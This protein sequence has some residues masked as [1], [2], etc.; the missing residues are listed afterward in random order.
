M[1]NRKTAVKA[2]R[3]ALLMVDFGL[4]DKFCDA[5]ELKHPW[6]T[7]R[8]TDELIFFFSVFFNIK[9]TTLLKLYYKG[10]DSEDILTEKQQLEDE[11]LSTNATK[12]RSLFQIM[13][14]NI[15]NGYQ[16]TPLHIMNAAE[17]YEKCKSRELITSFNIVGLCVG[18]NTLKRH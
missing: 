7:T 14:Y 3:E 15:H 11:K 2:I 5:E 6:S 18:Y 12:I 10:D 17:I 1:D 13:F 16:R 4:Q 9:E 8:M